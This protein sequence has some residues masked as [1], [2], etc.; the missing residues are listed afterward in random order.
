MVL[1]LKAI[2]QS[3]EFRIFSCNP[4][5]IQ[6]AFQVLSDLVATG[7]TLEQA[8]ILDSNSRTEL[9]VAAFDGQTSFL[10]ELYALQHDWE[11][12]LAKSSLPSKVD[13]SELI[14]LLKKRSQLYHDQIVAQQEMIDR[15]NSLLEQAYTCF[16]EEPRRSRLINS[17]HNSLKIRQTRLTGML[18]VRSD[19]LVKLVR[20]TN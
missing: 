6:A 2:D 5:S 4:R 11:A 8:Y 12:I 20:L 15:L 14:A 7:N 13:K 19:L 16:T 10:K 18:H 9:P 17:Y 3:Q 1:V